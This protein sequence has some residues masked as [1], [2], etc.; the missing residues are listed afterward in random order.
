MSAK[1]LVAICISLILLIGC[2]KET[3]KT[4]SGTYIGG[5]IINPTSNFLLLKKDDKLIDSIKLDQNNRFLYKFSDFKQGLYQ[6][7]HNEGQV[8][9]V[10]PN[11]SLLLRVNTFEFDE[12]LT[13]TG[14]GAVKNNLM[15]ELYLQNEQENDL[16]LQQEVYQQD[17]ET[18][19]RSIIKMKENREAIVSRF[20]QKY[21]ASVSFQ[22]I[23]HAIVDYDF[24]ARQE[25]YPMSHFGVDRIKFLESFPKSFYNYRE[26]ADFNDSGLLDLY[27]YQRFLINYFNQAAFKDYYKEEPYNPLSFTHNLHKLRIINSKISNDSV[28]SFLLTRTIKDYLANSNDKKGGQTLYDMY[29]ERITSEQDRIL[30]Q[31]LYEANK[32]IETGKHIPNEKL[33]NS[34]SDT[35]TLDQII[36]RPTFV[37]FWSS[38]RKSHA[39]RAQKLAKTLIQKYPEY[40]YIAI[41][42]NDDFDK[43]QRTI[44]RYQFDIAK[45]YF[46]KD[47][48]DELSQDLALNSLLKTFILDRNGI[49]INAHANIFSSN[50]E[51]E[52]LQGLNK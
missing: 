47:S 12:T 21:D 5:Q 3:Q 29:M 4:E 28:E 33:I 30:I 22:K 13:F 32:K 7:F 38:A 6:V 20:F 39:L 2:S 49:I 48:F 34:D 46:I 15:I 35:L 8:I 41:N 25:V 19:T 1:L 36:K 50:F 26:Q 40:T 16:M 52:L 45:Q 44:N 37:F 31:E 23:I 18:F 14:Y 27:S 42:V 43:W 24:Y 51:N 10:E 11:D 17:P 9:Y